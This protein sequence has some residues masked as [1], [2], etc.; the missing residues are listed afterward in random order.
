MVAR[1]VVSG[2]GLCA[3]PEPDHHKP[4]VV[5]QGQDSVLCF[6][7]PVFYGHPSLAFRQGALEW[8]WSF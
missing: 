2:P 3:A 1:H 5:A 4:A 6:L 8:E 7:D